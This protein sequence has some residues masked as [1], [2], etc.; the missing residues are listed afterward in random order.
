[1]LVTL[2]P[3]VAA[4]DASMA[5]LLP[6]DVIDAIVAE[7]PDAWLV[8][9]V[10]FDDGDAVRSAYRDRIVGRLAAREVWVPALA[11]T[12]QTRGGTRLPRRNQRP[13]WLTSGEVSRD[14]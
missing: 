14:R 10:D 4:I 5:G 1:M 2:A 3:D 13:D 11:A 6:V 8:D 9:E 12:A 7:V